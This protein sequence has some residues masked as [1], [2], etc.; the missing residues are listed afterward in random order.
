MYLEKRTYVKNWDHMD[1][2][3]RHE[4]N[5]TKNGKPTKIKPERIS[6]VIED[7]GYWRKAN[8]IHQWFVDNAQDGEDRNGELTYVNEEQMR[9]LLVTVKS[10]LQ[11]SKL[12]PGKV[13]VG[14]KYEDGKS[15]PI[16]ED[17]KVIEDPTVAKR[18]LPAQSGFFFGGT[19]YDEGY[20]NDL[21]HT[22]EILESCLNDDEDGDFYYH[23]SW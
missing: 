13:C 5:I 17:G 16:M 3:E 22:K 12:V 8:Q 23:S 18:L 9:E 20:Y 19:D 6:H 11:A 4:F 2:E 14:T 1:K 7:V 15:I 10:V 21:V